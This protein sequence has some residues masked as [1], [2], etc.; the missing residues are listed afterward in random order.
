MELKYNFI[1]VREGTFYMLMSTLIK[2]NEICLTV[3]KTN[4]SIILRKKYALFPPQ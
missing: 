2:Y 3:L 4:M 1:Y